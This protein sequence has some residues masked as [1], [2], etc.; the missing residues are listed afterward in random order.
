[1]KL[2]ARN[3]VWLLPLFLT[4]C[5]DKPHPQPAQEFAPP[6]ANL[7]KPPA[8]HPELPDSAVT[9]AMEP[10]DT[11]TDA[12]VED[13]AKPVVKHRK[14][15]TKTPTEGGDSAQSSPGAS[16]QAENDPSEVPAIGTLSSG[17][18]PASLPDLRSETAVSIT[19]TERG[20]KN[21]GRVLSSEEQKT[22]VQIR[23][24]IRQARKALNTGDVEGASTLAAKAKAL[25]TELSG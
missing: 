10:L 5:F 2:R 13:A 8:T 6:I 17:G 23:Q 3:V 25:L 24:Y 14:P 18:D 12:I 9:F 19:D 22:A 20:L 4:G 16:Q 21:I 7:P 11:D 15:V 1:M